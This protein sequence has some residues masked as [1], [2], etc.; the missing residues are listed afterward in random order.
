MKSRDSSAIGLCS[1]CTE[2]FKDCWCITV[3]DLCCSTK[4]NFWSG[5]WFGST[6][7]CNTQHC[8]P[9]SHNI[10]TRVIWALMGWFQSPLLIVL[11]GWWRSQQ[12]VM[13]SSLFQGI[14]CQYC[15]FKHCSVGTGLEGRAMHL[16]QASVRVWTFTHHCA[17]C[18]VSLPLEM[19]L[20]GGDPP[21]K[22]EEA[23]T[24]VWKALHETEA[25]IPHEKY[26]KSK[27]LNSFVH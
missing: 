3:L 14:E 4:W 21:E 27:L 13:A 24:A 10:N 1:A 16:L 12:R 8:K 23:T 25:E 22:V 18:A 17:G 7:S 26:L 15:I 9:N 6:N 5:S 19:K 11:P 20:I 2:W